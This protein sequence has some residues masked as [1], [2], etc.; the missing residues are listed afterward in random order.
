M[1]SGSNLRDDKQSV[2]NVTL[3]GALWDNY[4]SVMLL[5]IEYKCNYRN[6]LSE[7]SLSFRMFTILFADVRVTTIFPENVLCRIKISINNP[8]LF[9]PE[10]EIVLIKIQLYRRVGYSRCISYI[11]SI[12]GTLIKQ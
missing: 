8:Y 9:S 3:W 6:F 4:L 5:K 12:T 2:S 11:L 10:S 7:C 1:F